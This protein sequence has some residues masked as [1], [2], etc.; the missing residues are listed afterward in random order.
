MGTAK[1]NEQIALEVVCREES[2]R[3]WRLS[4]DQALDKMHFKD[5]DLNN[6]EGKKVFV[7]YLNGLSILQ[8]IN[9]TGGQ[10]ID[11]KR[12]KRNLGFRQNSFWLQEGNKEVAKTRTIP[13]YYLI[14]VTESLE[15]PPGWRKAKINEAS[16]FL[17]TLLE[18]TGERLLQREMHVAETNSRRGIVL[19]V[20]A[21]QEDKGLK[22]FLGPKKKLTYKYVNILIRES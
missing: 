15:T 14:R 10:T 12:T 2:L 20:G 1:N 4:S 22:L 8:Q 3:I 5:K 7:V 18:I 21:F 17:Q 16:E 13:G 11:T 9:K 19:A 6:V